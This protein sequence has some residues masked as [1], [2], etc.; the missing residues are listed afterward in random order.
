[1]NP[2]LHPERNNRTAEALIPL[3]ISF[4]VL[5]LG[6]YLYVLCSRKLILFAAIVLAVGCYI[7]TRYSL[8][9]I[10]SNVR[11]DRLFLYTLTGLSLF[12][13]FAFPPFSVPDEQYHF[14]NTY[15]YS[16][17]M[18]LQD[19]S[20]EYLTMRSSDLEMVRALNDQ[21]ITSDKYDT[22]IEKYSLFSDNSS[23]VRYDWAT[24]LSSNPIQTRFF[25]ALGISIARLLNLGS[26]PLFY[27]GR[28]FSAF[29]YVVLVYLA[30][31]ISPICKEVIIVL[32]LLPMSLHLAGSY[33]YDVAIIGLSFLLSASCLEAILTDGRLNTR[34]YVIISITSFLLAPCKSVYSL[35]SLLVFLIPAHNFPRKRTEFLF[36]LGVPALAIL[37][38]LLLRIDS[39]LAYV[40]PPEAYAGSTG[41]PVYDYRGAEAGHF[42]TISGLLNDPIGCMSLFVNTFVAQSGFYLVSFIG[43][44]LGW[45]QANMTSPSILIFLFVL[46]LLYSTQIGLSTDGNTASQMSLPSYRVAFILI[47][48]A[49]L[50]CVML[51]MALGWTFDNEMVIQGVQGRYFIPFSFVGLCAISSNILKT[52]LNGMVLCVSMALLLNSIN[53]LTVITK[54]LIA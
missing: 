49:Q 35:L 33:S 54:A 44:S 42:Y 22:V 51:S 3:I 25:P 12:F 37:S 28:L 29:S 50:L 53:C 6:I 23:I 7:T 36:K 20:D 1:M 5:G 30:Y 24:T 17:I 52:K 46:L 32:S 13:T 21:A 48:I 31:R 15:R 8:S 19:S 38:A 39:I 2:A 14:L 47:S 4:G 9:F 11:C 27:L 16:D 43:G 41:G 10:K 18:L 34:Q 40:L 26:I 45:F